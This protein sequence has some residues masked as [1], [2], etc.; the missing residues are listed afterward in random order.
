MARK[1]SLLA[2]RPRLRRERGLALPA[3]AALV[4]VINFAGLAAIVVVSIAATAGVHAAKP[5][6]PPAFSAPVSRPARRSARRWR[7]SWPPRA[8][9]PVPAAL[10]AR[11][12]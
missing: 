3:V 11:A 12:V 2:P 10:L 9:A 4:A 6:S 8:R 7:P 1:D 5:G